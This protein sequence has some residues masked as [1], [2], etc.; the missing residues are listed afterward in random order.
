MNIMMDHN[1]SLAAI[2]VIHVVKL[3]LNVLNADHLDTI[4]PIVAIA[5]MVDT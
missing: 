2:N 3:R 4:P 5:K 1:V